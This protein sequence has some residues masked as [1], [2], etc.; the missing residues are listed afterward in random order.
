MNYKFTKLLN[1]DPL[2]QIRGA[3]RMATTN[4]SSGRWVVETDFKYSNGLKANHSEYFWY[5]T[6][7]QQF[8]VY[9]M[10]LADIQEAKIIC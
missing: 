6:E 4:S 5:K 3:S 1:N 8:L 9:I 10:E 7:A 2:L